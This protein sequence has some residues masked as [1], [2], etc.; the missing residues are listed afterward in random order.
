VGALAGPLIDQLFEGQ[1]GAEDG[2]QQFHDW[3]G[4][5]LAG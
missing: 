4:A 1:L 5:L 2:A 3:P